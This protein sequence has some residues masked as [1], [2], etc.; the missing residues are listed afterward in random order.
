MSKRSYSI[1]PLAPAHLAGLAAF[2]LA[3]SFAFIRPSLAAIPLAAF[4]ATCLVAPFIQRLRFYL[5]IARRG[6]GRNPVVAI[7]FDDGPDPTTTSALLELLAKHSVRATFFL[8]GRNV[9]EHPDLVS[10]ILSHGH[11]VGNHSNSHDVFLMLRRPET[12]VAEIAACQNVLR[13]FGIKPLAFRPP[14]GITNPY[15]F[16]ALIQL[17]MYCAG[18][19]CRGV[20][21]GNQ[22]IAGLAR[23]TLRCARA[24]DVVLL[25]DRLP[26]RGNS[27][28]SWL[29]EIDTLLSGLR[30]KGLQ[31]TP[32]S[33]VIERPVMESVGSEEDTNLVRTFYNGLAEG[34]DA[35]Q[36]MVGQSFVRRAEWE[37]VMG[38]LPQL[39]RCGG[40]VLEIGAGTG[41]FTLTMAKSVRRVMAVDISERMLNVL[42]QKA[43]NAGIENITTRQGDMA[44]FSAEEPF[45]LICAFSCLE[46]VV[47]LESLLRSLHLFLK[48]DG[49]L[50][51]TIAHRSLFRLFG[52]IGNA[53][54]QGVWLHARS[55]M[56]ITRMLRAAGFS[57]LELSAHALKSVVSSGILLEVIARK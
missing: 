3:A 31:P 22:R 44:A 39:L 11:E 4:L 23:R 19:S 25:H 45:D 51:F 35:E 7:T 53:M 34:Y 27:V 55:K 8:I 37:L 54:R 6:V 16:R 47:D 26:G 2:Q 17:G 42:D 41:R 30:A 5:P 1:C 13:P 21:F 43:K 33:E 29:Q 28:G 48:P 46:Y 15:L 57:S 40:S 24:G 12:L 18:F 49:T 9:S 36:E 20:D 10:E 14:V 38:R 50:Y 32:L 56:E 52:Q